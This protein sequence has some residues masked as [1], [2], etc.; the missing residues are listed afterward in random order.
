[1]TPDPTRPTVQPLASAVPAKI[2]SSAAV[3][4]A[5][6][7]FLAIA[8]AETG[9]EGFQA[10]FTG[11]QGFEAAFDQAIVNQEGTVVQRT[12]GTLQIMRPGRFRWSYDS[13]YRQTIVTDGKTLWVYDPDLGQVTQ[14]ALDTSVGNTPAMLLSTDRPLDELFRIAESP[15]RDGLAW[16]TLEPKAQEA[17]FSRVQLGFDGRIM[18]AMD[19]LDSFGQTVELRFSR[20]R[21][22]P[23]L[24]PG[25]FRF[26]PPEGVDVIGR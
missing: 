3:L 20:I 26:T 16:V 8:R 2:L 5:L 12:H 19:I 4:A 15:P 25:L 17:N 11:L 1:V 6:L 24:D 23:D 13:P 18:T 21:R 22:N 10:F 7:S 14:S 9:Q